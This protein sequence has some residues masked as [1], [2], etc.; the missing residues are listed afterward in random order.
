MLTLSAPTWQTRWDNP[1]LIWTCWHTRKMDEVLRAH[2]CQFTCINTLAALPSLGFHLQ[3]MTLY[4]LIPCRNMHFF[5][6]MVKTS[7]FQRSTHL[8]HSSQHI[9][10]FV[11]QKYNGYKCQ[12]HSRE[13]AS[14]ALPADPK[15]CCWKMG[16]ACAVPFPDFYPA[17]GFQVFHPS[18]TWN[19]LK[20][21]F[22]GES[23]SKGGVW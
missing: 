18:K 5:F 22:R 21:N 17:S 6:P 9:A 13:A 15:V 19:S 7:W 8:Q 23:S 3:L 11:F 10:S 4:L 16:I 2:L 12:H 14:G 20:K 1:S